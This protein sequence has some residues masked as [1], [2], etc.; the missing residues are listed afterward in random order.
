MQAFVANGG[1]EPRRN[2]SGGDDGQGRGPAPVHPLRRLPLSRPR[3]KV[4]GQGIDA[5][6][7]V[8][9]LTSLSKLCPTKAGNQPFLIL[10]A[11]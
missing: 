11:T 6:L 10:D 5:T 9:H 2:V 3:V 1:E 8:V 7:E 4:S